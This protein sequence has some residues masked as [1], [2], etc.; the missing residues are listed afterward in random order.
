MGIM[1]CFLIF[2]KKLRIRDF[3]YDV[4]RLQAELAVCLEEHWVEHFNT[5]DFKG[6][7]QGISLRSASGDPHD[8]TSNYGASTYQDTALL[9]NLPYIQRIIHDLPGQKEAIRFLALAPGSEIKAHKDLGCGYSQGNFRLHIPILTDP[10]VEFMLDGERLHLQQGECWYM[11]FNKIH[12]I[13]N[14]STITRI[15][16]VIDVLRDA[17]TDVLFAAYGWTE[18]E[19]VRYSRETLTLMFDALESMNTDTARALIVQLKESH[20]YVD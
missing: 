9:A 15:H 10:L 20:Q 13:Y 6:L 8:I 2:N 11:D 3:T 7:W 1:I 17:Q 19:P 4:L 18:Q 5:K 16:L 14:A 12:Q